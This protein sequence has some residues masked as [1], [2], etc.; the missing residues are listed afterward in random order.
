MFVLRSI[1]SFQRMMEPAS[2]KDPHVAVA[3]D[4]LKKLNELDDFERDAV[5]L[6]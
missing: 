5:D 6:I 2:D 4:F 1:A 3:K